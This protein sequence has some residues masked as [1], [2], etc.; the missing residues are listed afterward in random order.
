MSDRTQHESECTFLTARVHPL[1]GEL[2]PT[3][4]TLAWYKWA[5]KPTNPICPSCGVAVDAD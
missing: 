4:K 5:T 1:D 3:Q 2:A